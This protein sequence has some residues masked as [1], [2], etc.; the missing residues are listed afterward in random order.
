MIEG[1]KILH[2]NDIAHLDIRFENLFLDLDYI[3]KSYEIQKELSVKIGWL[4]FSRFGI[5][6]ISSERIIK[7]SEKY[8]PPEASNLFNGMKSDIWQAA[9]ILI[10]L[11]TG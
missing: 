4:G 6:S 7:G 11:Y 3:E 1:L 9:L 10:G 5:S 8:F 2:D